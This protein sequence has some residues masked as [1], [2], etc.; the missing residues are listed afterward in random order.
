MEFFENADH[1]ISLPEFSL[2]HQSKMARDCCVKSSGVVCTG[3]ENW[4]LIY[5]H[6]P[7]KQINII[8][9]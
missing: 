3:L 7:T 6:A 2:K 4:S 8:M 1:V 9:I 5:K